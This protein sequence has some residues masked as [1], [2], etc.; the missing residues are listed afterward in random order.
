M[1]ENKF[2]KEWKRSDIKSISHLNEDYYRGV[3]PI[4]GPYLEDEGSNTYSRAYDAKLIGREIIDNI[5]RYNS[6]AM[7]FSVHFEVKNNKVKIKI[8]HYGDHF[9]PFSPESKCKLIKKIKSDINFKSSTHLS[10]SISYNMT[11]AFDL[12]EGGQV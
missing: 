7:R 5:F 12:R 2:F 8:R 6:L 1:P 11:I 4:I 3:D 10:D 9:D